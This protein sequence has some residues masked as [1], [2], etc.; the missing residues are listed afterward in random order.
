MDT[1]AILT[2]A[3]LLTFNSSC[4]DWILHRFVLATAL[5]LQLRDPASISAAEKMNLY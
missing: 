4:N 3:D 5:C 2:A 1:A